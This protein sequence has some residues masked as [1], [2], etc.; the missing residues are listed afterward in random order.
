MRSSLPLL[1]G[2]LTPQVGSEER[3]WPE[4]KVTAVARTAL[5]VARYFIFD[6]EV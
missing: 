3:L 2:Q 4:L 5:A 1:L 6:F